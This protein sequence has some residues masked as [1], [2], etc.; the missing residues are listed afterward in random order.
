MWAFNDLW[1]QWL[2]VTPNHALQRTAAGRRRCNR[3][4]A[5]PPSVSLGRYM[6]KASRA[7][8]VHGYTFA[9]RLFQGTVASARFVDSGS[10][11]QIGAPE[12]AVNLHAFRRPG[13][14]S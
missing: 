14:S 10:G 7:S 6:V 12:V 5:W 2:A 8:N 9:F 11:M 13:V 3:C 1:C 4:G